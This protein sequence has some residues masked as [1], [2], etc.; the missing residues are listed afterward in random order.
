[1]RVYVSLQFN[2]QYLARH[3][4]KCIYYWRRILAHQLDVLP[5]CELLFHVSLS[6]NLLGLLLSLSL[7]INSPFAL[8]NTV[9]ISNIWLLKILSM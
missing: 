5:V 8:S 3:C 1:M 7:L 9:A 4:F 2:R 6:I